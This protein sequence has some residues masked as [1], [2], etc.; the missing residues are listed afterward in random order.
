[1]LTFLAIFCNFYN[2]NVLIAERVLATLKVSK[3][4]RIDS[5]IPKTAI[6]LIIA[7]VFLHYKIVR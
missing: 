6:S 4:E 7:Q 3:Y 5:K 1:M 2:M